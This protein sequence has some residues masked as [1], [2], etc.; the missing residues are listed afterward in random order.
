MKIAGQSF[1]IAILLGFIV[2][3]IGIWWAKHKEI[4]CDRKI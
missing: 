3:I 4:N 2:G 1:V